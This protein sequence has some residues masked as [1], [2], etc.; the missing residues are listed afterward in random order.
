VPVAALPNAR[1][2]GVPITTLVDL[3]GGARIAHYFAGNA[4]TV[5]LASSTGNGFCAKAGDMV[6]RTKGGKTFITL[7]EGALPL[8]PKV[9]QPGAVW[10]ACVSDG[11]R[12]LVFGLDEMKTLSNGGRGVTL[13]ELDDGEQLLTAQP[14]GPKSVLVSGIGCGAKPQDATLSASGLAA[15]VG[16]RGRKGKALAA[17]LKPVTLTA[18]G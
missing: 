17:K 3:S 11:A 7:D 6:S 2:D 15:H 9:V 1:G 12:V 5:L 16:K 13:M 4:A 10:V 14:I 8:P 18:L